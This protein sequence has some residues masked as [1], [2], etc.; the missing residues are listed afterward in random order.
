MRRTDE[1]LDL[2]ILR[3]DLR[4]DV[5]DRLVDEG[6]PDLFRLSHPAQDSRDE[7]DR[8]TARFPRIVV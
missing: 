3:L 4:D 8:P 7:S 6:K 5:A 1:P 2:G